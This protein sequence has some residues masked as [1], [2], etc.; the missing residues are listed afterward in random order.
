MTSTE[1]ALMTMLQQ[2][3][4]SIIITWHNGCYHWQCL[5]CNGSA[6][7]PILWESLTVH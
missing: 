1:Q 5:D 7:E 6:Q 2:L 3:P 4:T